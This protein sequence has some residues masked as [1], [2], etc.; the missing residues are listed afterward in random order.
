MAKSYVTY[1]GN[2][3]TTT[4]AITF[5]YL[6]KLHV[7]VLIAGEETDAWEWLTPS[8]IK[9]NTPSTEIKTI[10]RVT[11]TEPIVDFTDGSVLTE[12]QLDIA[13]LQSLYVAEETQDIAKYSL[14]SS[15]GDPDGGGQTP[16]DGVNWNADGKKIINLKSGTNAKD[17]INKGQLDA[18]VPS[19]AA[20]V[21]KAEDAADEAEGHADD[22][23]AAAAGVNA[24]SVK[25]EN[26]ANAA[27]VSQDAA[28]VSEDA[29]KLS[30][31][32]ANSSK[33]SAKVSE[34]NAK[35]SADKAKVSELAA[36]DSENKAKGSAADAALAA[37]TVNDVV[38]EVGDLV[39]EAE[40]HALD[41]QASADA[42]ASSAVDSSNSADKAQAHEEEAQAIVDGFNPAL[43][44]KGTIDITGPAPTEKATGDSYTNSTAGVASG[45]W[46]T[47]AGTYVEKDALVIYN[48][49]NDWTATGIAVDQ[50]GY[51]KDQTDTLLDEKADVGDSYTKAE[52]D[53]VH[54]TKA[55]KD[56]TYTKDEVDTS[57]D[58]KTNVADN[59]WVEEGTNIAVYSSTGN[60]GVIAKA[61]SGGYPTFRVDNEDQKYS[62]QVRP[63]KLNSF[64]IKNETANDYP[65]AISS[66]SILSTMKD[67]KV[68]G[69]NVGTGGGTGVQNTA[70][71]QNSLKD[72]VYAFN[73]TAI[74]YSSGSLLTS[75]ENNT[76]I[77][78]NAQPSSLTVSN[79]VTI[80]NDAVT[81]TR[82]NGEVQTTQ[83]MVVNGINVGTGGNDNRNT[84]IGVNAIKNATKPGNTALG[85]DAGTNLTT[86]SNCTMIGRGAEPSSPDANNEVTLGNSGVTVVRMGN[87]QPLTTTFYVQEQI[88]I[89]DKLIEKLSARLD[90]LEKRMK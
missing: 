17:G 24:D 55:D 20:E 90:K 86:G 27:K 74:G 37:E 26:A 4:Y 72:N 45:T 33:V 8:S 51:T 29:A 77:G 54:N 46:R 1:P 66:D 43:V 85:Y 47:L 65:L 67:I 68:N 64:I 5:P 87:G 35:D 53:A 25:A 23:K 71:G 49:K 21:K 78:Y 19:L 80:G 69:V 12:N 30:E 11:P 36:K 28:K 81:V 38:A 40:G 50:D 89:K 70:I 16:G 18:V 15:P 58:T 88:S 82:L 3:T 84:A 34:D 9:L 61:N 42:S 13:T 10:V 14:G 32:A 76:F 2:G 59:I 73:S 31:S 22:A 79:E 44:Y 57:L 62:M 7:H 41:S 52:D 60:T 6:A 83:D 75:G 56:D 63:D 48:D 39:D